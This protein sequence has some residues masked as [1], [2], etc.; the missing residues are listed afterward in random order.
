MKTDVDSWLVHCRDGG[1][2][3]ERTFRVLCEKLKEVLVEESNLQPVSAPVTIVGKI[4]GQ[5]NDLIK[6]LEEVGEVPARKFVFL[7]NYCSQ[8]WQCIE[9]LHFLFCLKL[10]YPD[11]VTLLRGRNDARDQTQLLSLLYV[12]VQKK[13]GNLNV[14]K[15]CCEVFNF[16]PLAALVEGKIFCVCGGLTPDLP[17]L[18]QINLLDRVRETP[19]EGPMVDLLY[20]DP[21]ENDGWGFGRLAGWQFGQ[22]ITQRFCHVNDLSLIARTNCFNGEGFQYWHQRLVLSI[23]STPNFCYRMVNRGAVCHINEADLFAEIYQYDA[24]DIV[25]QLV[26]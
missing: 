26:N 16:L 22:N 3:P 4:N 24:S 17:Q 12:S 9:C 10:K 8:G 11:H 21:S 25:P 15:Y 18:D 7:G 23:W 5:F 19:R 14:W 1:L 2:L 20:S 6:M 13:Y